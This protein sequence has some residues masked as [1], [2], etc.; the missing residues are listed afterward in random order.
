M[1]TGTWTHIST[2]SYHDKE[3]LSSSRN[4]HHTGSSTQVW[5]KT[6]PNTQW[7]QKKKLSKW[8]TSI[9][10]YIR[11]HT[12]LYIFIHTYITNTLTHLYIHRHL[13]FRNFDSLNILWTLFNSSVLLRMPFFFLLIVII[14]VIKLDSN[15]LKFAVSFFVW[16]TW[17]I[18]PFSHLLLDET[19]PFLSPKGD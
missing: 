5:G 16:R 9:H 6:C 7:L 17:R 2:Y 15:L 18:A 4:S 12:H 3:S 11:I 10:K 13:I 19:S 1:H 8:V 14:S